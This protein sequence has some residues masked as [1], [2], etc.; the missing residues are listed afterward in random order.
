MKIAAR[1]AVVVGLVVTVWL[2][3]PQR[4]SDPR[5][6]YEAYLNSHP[7]T[8]E[9]AKG[10]KP[11]D[12]KRR[13]DR[14]DLAFMQEYLRTMDPSLGRPVPEIL[15]D[16]NIRTARIRDG[17]DFS[18]VRQGAHSGTSLSTATIWE[19]R[20]PR[21][22]GGRTRALL[23]DPADANARKVW[24]GGVSGG[25]WYIDDITDPSAVWQKVDDFWDNL[26]VSC[27]AADPNNDQI[28]YVGTGES[29][30]G[31]R[32]AGIWKTTDGGQTWTS[33]PASADLLQV[34]DI[35]VRNEDGTSVVYAAVEVS[36]GNDS[37][38]HNQG[39]YRS[40]DGGA[41]WQQVLPILATNGNRP[42]TATDIEIGDDEIWVGTKP[43]YSNSTNN[44]I[45]YR[46]T[47]GT[48]G[49][50][51]V[52]NLNTTG[53]VELAVAPSNPDVVYALLEDEGTVA[54]IIKTTNEGATWETL[55][56]PVDADTGIPDDDF[57]RG[58][59]WYDLTAAV[60][61]TNEN[62]IIVGAIDLFRSGN[63][64]NSWTQI[65]KW[66]S[67][68]AV[69][70]PVVHADQHAI[71]YRPGFPNQVIFGTDGGVYYGT[72]I[73]TA[74]VDIVARNNSYNVTQFYSAALHPTLTNYMLGGTQDNGT[75]KFTASGFGN[76]SEVIGGDGA[77]CFIDQNDPQFQIG[78]Y[79]YNTYYLS[80]NGGASFNTTL[81]DDMSSG[82]FINVAEYDSDNKILY[83]AK[84]SGSLYKV[85]QVTTTPV[86]S[87]IDFD[88]G[89]MASALRVSSH[90]SANLY[91]GT[92]TGRLFRIENA[93]AS[94]PDITEITGPDFPTGSI[95]GIAFGATEDQILVTFFNYGVVNIWETRDGGV[96]WIDREGDLPNMPVRWVEYHPH[97]PDQAYIA[98]QLGVWSTDNINVAEPEWLPTN[99]G[100]ANV[101]TD[102]LRMRLDDGLLMAST[103]GRG[104]FT[105]II[106]SQLAQEIT[107]EEL[108]EKT[109][110]DAPFDLVA[111][112][113][114]D[115]TVEFTSSDTSIAFILGRTVTIKA[116]GTVTIT[117]QQPG[118]A[119]FA[120][121]D[122]VGRTLNINKAEQTITFNE[123][124]AKGVNDEPFDLTATASSGLPV[125]FTSSNPAVATVSGN[126]ITI[127]GAPGTATITAMQP[128]D[129]NY[130]PAPDVNR[131]LVVESRILEINGNTDFGEVIVGEQKFMEFIL[132]DVGTTAVTITAIQVPPDFHAEVITEGSNRILVVGFAPTTDT[133]YNAT[134]SLTTN[135]TSGPTSVDVTGSGILIT[136]IAE[137][138]SNVLKVY[139]NPVSDWL[140]IAAPNVH[141]LR[142]ISFYNMEGRRYT[143]PTEPQNDSEVRVNV[144]PLPSGTYIIGIPVDNTIHYKKIILQQP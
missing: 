23:F 2:F 103:Y 102:M 44:S 106:P 54:N 130:L 93:N 84:T 77:M 89:S 36:I 138:N 42:N 95:S 79:V 56:K 136:N 69:T 18:M 111:T 66:W 39:L 121:A 43:T 14:A 29:Q 142:E 91:V 21:V 82:N 22:V 75:Q 13:R 137:T 72:N 68:I 31:M 62:E 96:N 83:T 19:E 117:A 86:Q 126:T 143:R 94:T 133:D 32:G 112:S 47:T 10:R 108:P 87:S 97:N 70:A 88:F 8:L 71:V 15:I 16:Q 48:A 17:K 132:Q 128:G 50:W 60:N 73:N 52:I 110:G 144:T 41:S 35:A 7:Y 65:S 9:I 81:L 113:T 51:Q 25:L 12:R 5:K 85:T 55:N 78:S 49:S 127:Q 115:L 101:R 24:A 139:P 122:P 53:Q 131:D 104:V 38:P 4:D 11:G 134:I 98:T 114:S 57:S 6:D 105:A 99:G 135:A 129:N 100:L 30:V 64:G 45:I 34:R 33:L 20:G 123:L 26:S 116:A 125:S 28:M 3:M 61:P 118:N 80:S 58:Q 1:A 76:T 37:P 124:V 119:Y 59:A 63:G 90:N 67:G 107:F 40:A 120:A 109:Y 140:V 92:M 27:I 141:A 46:S 74:G